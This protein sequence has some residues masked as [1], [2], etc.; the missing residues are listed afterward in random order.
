LEF[1]LLLND[2]KIQLSGEQQQPLQFD[3]VDHVPA[4]HRA[5]D[6]YPTQ[7]SLLN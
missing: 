2:E 7:Q 6:L 4:L 5:L 1:Q 3:P